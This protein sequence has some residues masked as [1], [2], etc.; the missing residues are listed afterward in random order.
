MTATK[1]AAELKFT[2]PANYR[3]HVRG[4]LDESWSERLI[5]MTIDN[6]LLA[7]AFPV[8][9]LSGKVRDQAEL[10]GVLGGI[11]EMHLPLISVELF[12]SECCSN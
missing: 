2:S 6:Q 9:I 7:K 4:S 8:A 1:L 12:D 5:G 10:F 3:I 11:Y